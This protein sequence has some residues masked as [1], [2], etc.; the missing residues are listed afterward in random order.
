MKLSKLAYLCIKNVVYFDDSSFTY[1]EF[2]K[3]TFKDS[4]DYSVNINN[5]YTPLN[6]AI[7]RLS[8]LERIPY[9][10][11][12]FEVN[13]N[14]IDLTNRT[15]KPQIKEVLGVA[16]MT[17]MGTF[18][19]V[20]HRKFGIDKLF[21]SDLFSPLKKVFVEYKEDIPTFNDSY[22]PTYDYSISDFD[23]SKDKEMREYGITDS[24]CNYIIEYVS[25]RLQEPI[26][27]D[28]SNMHI[29]RA[30]QYFANM[31]PTTSAFA[32]K[33]VRNTYRVGE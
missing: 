30:E 6:E 10:I 21:V 12:E 8:D 2:L 25:G 28:I 32:Q 20:E 17:S 16:K 23:Y 31:K 14:F 18:R 24:M 22:I 9:R 3:G 5:V 4:P 27:A 13:N 11:E 1:E 26:N 15:G 29:T 19:K 33:V 7:A